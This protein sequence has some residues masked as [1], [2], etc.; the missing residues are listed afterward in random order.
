M[1]V[2]EPVWMTYNLSNGESLVLKWGN[3]GYNWLITLYMF[4]VYDIIF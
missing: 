1:R 2:S 4:P 3:T